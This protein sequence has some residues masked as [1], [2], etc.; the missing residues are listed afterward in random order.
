DF[1]TQLLPDALTK[2]GMVIGLLGGLWPGIAGELISDSAVSPALR[3]LLASP[4][5]LAVGGG[6]VWLV[7]AAGSHVFKKE[8]MGFGDVK[9]AAPLGA[10]LGWDGFLVG[11]LFAVV[12]GAVIGVA[13]R[14]L[15]GS[16]FVPFGPFL[17]VGAFLALAFADP[18]IRWYLGLLGV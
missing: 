15:G 16:R 17:V 2:P 10:F 4:V 1:D 14:L 5:G 13:Q 6:T 3:T 18:L 9:L 12:L 11:L 7:R 8:A